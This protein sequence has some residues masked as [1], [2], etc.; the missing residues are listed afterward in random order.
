VARSLALLGAGFWLG[1]LVASWVLASISFR[2]ATE[3]L[4]PGA[5][6]ELTNGL[7]GTP[8]APLR[9]A[10]RYM[11]SEI[12]RAMFG[13]RFVAE[14][15]LGAATLAL[16]FRFGGPWWPGAIALAILAVQAGLHGPILE[17]GRAADFMPRPLPADMAAR[18]GR[19]HGAYVLLDFTKAGVV[20]WWAFL[21]ARLA[22]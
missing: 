10:L 19:L 6:P 11:A 18:F 15:A 16:A 1:I 8:E 7:A 20:A 4:G 3:L 17:I 12:N 13:R 9:Q 21:L 22:R 2:T 14:I 5:R